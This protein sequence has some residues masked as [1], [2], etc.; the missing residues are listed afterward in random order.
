VAWVGAATQQSA[1]AR[2]ETA[3]FFMPYLT[4]FLPILANAEKA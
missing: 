4:A 3:S 1:R 2:S